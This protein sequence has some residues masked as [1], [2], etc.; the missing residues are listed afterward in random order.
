LHW[1][2]VIV[3]FSFYLGGKNENH[4]KKLKSLVIKV[5]KFDVK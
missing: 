1:S 3:G 4:W 2:L 5:K